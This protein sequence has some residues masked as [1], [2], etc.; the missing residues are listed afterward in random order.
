[1]NRNNTTTHGVIGNRALVGRRFDM[2]S[3]RFS[4]ETE[5]SEISEFERP[6]DMAENKVKNHA[7][8]INRRFISENWSET[9]LYGSIHV[10]RVFEFYA[11]REE[12]RESDFSGSLHKFLR[13]WAIYIYSCLFGNLRRINFNNIVSCSLE[14]NILVLIILVSTRTIKF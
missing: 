6:L 8:H 5:V 12:E 4:S 2:S 11:E 14:K 10:S 1:M 9:I 13:L 3:S 7:I